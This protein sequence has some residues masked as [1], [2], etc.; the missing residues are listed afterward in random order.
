MP[1]ADPRMDY[2][3]DRKAME[4]QVPAGGGE[5]LSHIVH[6]STTLIP[7]HRSP[8]NAAQAT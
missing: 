3:A 7:A 8:C 5:R 2:T 6:E 1:P 4:I